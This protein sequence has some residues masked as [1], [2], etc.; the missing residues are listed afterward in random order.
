M[1]ASGSSV[2][3]PYLAVLE[4]PQSF[5]PGSTFIGGRRGLLLLEHS[6]SLEPGFLS[7]HPAAGGLVADAGTGSTGHMGHEQRRRTGS[8]SSRWLQGRE[9]VLALA[10]KEGGGT[11]TAAAELAPASEQQRR[12]WCCWKSG[13]IPSSSQLQYSP[14]QSPRQVAQS[15]PIMLLKV[16]QVNLARKR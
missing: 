16:T 13:A 7:E 12:L 14:S 15:G 11:F 4:S 6:S 8:L 9:R 3:R 5:V 1:Q 2:A 10:H